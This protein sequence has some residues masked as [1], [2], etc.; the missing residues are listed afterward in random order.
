MSE[1]DIVVSLLQHDANRKSLSTSF[2]TLD[3][4][5]SEIV[6]KEKGCLAYT[7]HHITFRASHY[8]DSKKS[9]CRMSVVSKIHASEQGKGLYGTCF[10]SQS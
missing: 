1:K 7:A 2:L 8:T 6:L 3:E 4:Q 10:D 5:N 9:F